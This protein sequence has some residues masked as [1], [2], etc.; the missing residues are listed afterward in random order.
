MSNFVFSSIII[1]QLMGFL[2]RSN[3]QFRY[4]TYP[5]VLVSSQDGQYNLSVCLLSQNNVLNADSNFVSEII[6]KRQTKDNQLGKGEM[7]KTK[8]PSRNTAF[9]LFE[10]AGLGSVCSH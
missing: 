8:Q 6:S 7:Q 5:V 1:L 10:H 3:S 4:E 9:Q 2:P